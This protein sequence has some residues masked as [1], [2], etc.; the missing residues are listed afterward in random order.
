MEIL[1]LSLNAQSFFD[2]SYDSLINHLS[3]ASSLKRAKTA[4]GA[5]RYLGANN[6]NVIIVTDEGLVLPENRLVLDK[7]LAYV[8]NGGLAIVG[9]HFPNFTPMDKFD[10]YIFNSILPILKY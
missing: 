8:Q 6:P 9:L 2:Q 7:L 5:I 10:K 3:N 1:L 4:A